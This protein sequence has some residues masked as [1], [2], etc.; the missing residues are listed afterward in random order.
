MFAL[1]SQNHFTD[2]TLANSPSEAHES[3][4]SP[5]L[6]PVVLGNPVVHP[7][8]CAVPYQY[9]S[10]VSILGGAAFIDS[11]LIMLERVIMSGY[12]RLPAP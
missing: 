11:S 9:Y 1:D 3:A 5:V 4:L 8:L 10:M 6:A 12:G 7:I 2:P